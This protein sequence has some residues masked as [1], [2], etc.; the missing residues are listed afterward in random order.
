M[1][2]IAHYRSFGVPALIGDLLISG[3]NDP[4]RPVHIPASR[5]IND[6]IFLPEN[7][8]IVGLNQK[9]ILCDDKLALAWSGSRFQAA[10]VVDAWQPLRYLAD[11][12]PAMVESL[13]DGV[14]NSLRNDLSLII[15][16]ATSDAVHLITR[17]VEQPRDYG[18]ITKVIAVGSGRVIFHDLVGQQASTVRQ[19]RASTTKN[20]ATDLMPIL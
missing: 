9:I 11:I 20:C 19:Y 15:A 3:R 17:N 13:L 14:D 1:T 12:D 5:S 2:I 18:D 10:N 8:F 4:R 6:R 7:T 16:V